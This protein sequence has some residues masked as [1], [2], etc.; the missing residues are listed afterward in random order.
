MFTLDDWVKFG[1]TR[2]GR[3]VSK[4]GGEYQIVPADLNH[5]IVQFTG[6]IARGKRLEWVVAY[7]DSRNHVLYQFDEKELTR[8]EMVNGD[9]R[10]KA[11]KTAHGM[12]RDVY[13]SFAIFITPQ[14]IVTKVFSDNNW[15]TLD[16]F[17][18]DAVPMGKFG[19]HIPGRD[20]V[21]LSDFKIMPN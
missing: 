12:K 16:E 11:K 8:T 17:T 9:R 6:I 19:F 10:G 14:S 4:Q 3:V 20:Q 2:D 7:R 18:M 1:W 5:A 15:K 13:N 21:A